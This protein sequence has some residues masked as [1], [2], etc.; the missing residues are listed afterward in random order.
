MEPQ[1]YKLTV[2]YDGTAY[3]GWQVQKN[4]VTIQQV[5]ETALARILGERI[6]ITGSGRTDAGVHALAQVASF[7]ARTTIPTA[8]LA[9]ALNGNLP[10]DIRVIHLEE[11][12]SDFHAI[13]SARWKVYRYGIEDGPV[14][15][16][17]RRFFCW[18]VRTRLDEFRMQE[19][20][21]FLLGRHDFASFQAANSPRASTVR[22]LFRLHVERAEMDA[23]QIQIEVGADGFLYNM[24]RNIVGTL[25]CVG[26]GEQP[27][28]W[29]RS[30]LEARNRKQ[31][32]PTAPPHG[33]CLMQVG[34]DDLPEQSP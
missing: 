11:V 10:D 3:S 16:V 32:A 1:N 9:R 27:P 5:L 21:Q 22:T 7:A 8:R 26:R 28:T 13:R 25:V 20:G 23:D 34:F 33:L 6:R 17:F 12:P 2:S 4:G 18:H 19:A 24:V 31:A 15:N 29:V 14:P 30:V